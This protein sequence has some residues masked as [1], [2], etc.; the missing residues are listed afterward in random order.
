[1][2][3]IF[4][5][6]SINIHEAALIKYLSQKYEVSLI[7]QVSQLSNRVRDS[8]WDIPDIGN[9][10][11]YISPKKDI[12]QNFYR[13]DNTIHIISGFSDIYLKDI[14]KYKDKTSKIG[15]TTES[16][17]YLDPLK[18]LSRWKYLLYR[19]SY[20]GK[21]DFILA[22]GQKAHEQMRMI[23]FKKHK[24]FDWAYFTKKINRDIVKNTQ[25]SEQISL[26]FVGTINDRKNVL[27][28]VDIHKKISN[29]NIILNIVGSGNMVDDLLSSIKDYK[30]IH[31]LGVKRNNEIAD[32]MLNSDLFILPSKYDGWGAVV[33]ESLLCGLPVVVSSYCASHIL[34]KGKRGKFFSI[35]ENNLLEV[36]NEQIKELPYS[37]QQREE[38]K[39]WAEN[40]ITAEVAGKYLL[41]IIENV[42]SEYK[43]SKP[44]APWLE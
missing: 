6:L 27:Y 36:L 25:H 4:Y 1:M 5:S 19:L 26:L 20:G 23:G 44:V 13:S 34:V 9:T 3:F 17:R 11:V 39:K 24:V 43:T 41:E 40:N 7:V 12:M 22:I 28:L 42:F 37:L 21:I 30:N 33:N 18:Y 29:P 16:F 38:I 8:G 10:K 35:K 2:K 31:Y 14:V 32:L 15:I